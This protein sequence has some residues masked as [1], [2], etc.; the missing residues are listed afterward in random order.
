MRIVTTMLDKNSFSFNRMWSIINYE[1]RGDLR[2]KKVLFVISFV[3]VVI[4]LVG[5]F[6]RVFF[7][8]G[9]IVG[10]EYLWSE[11][12]LVLT[13][14]FIAGIFPMI[15]GG[16]ISVDSIAWEIDKGTIIPLLSQP[17]KKSEIY[18]GKITEKLLLVSAISMLLVILSIF[19]AIMVGG[20]QK[21]LIWAIPTA[22]CLMLEIM[23]FVSFTFMLGALIKQSGFMMLILT[24]IYFSIL[25][26]SVFVMVK[27]GFHL[28]M[29]LIP[30]E[31]INNLLVSLQHFFLDPNGKMFVSYNLGPGL[32]GGAWFPASELLLY[33]FIGASISAFVFTIMGYI[34]F[35]RLEIR[36]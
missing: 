35:S 27:Q 20:G 29:T 25:I 6:F 34:L 26:G 28:W 15:L 10:S 21:Y 9:S 3:F 14:E 12:V 7:P 13:N 24:G 16:I 23:V 8:K 11:M 4:V 31:G 2:R 1:L 32:S 36:G 33:S 18:F 5:V 22:L 30:L 19:I 17:I